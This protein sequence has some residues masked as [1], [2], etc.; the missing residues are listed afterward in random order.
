MKIVANKHFEEEKPHTRI[1]HELFKNAL[2]ASINIANALNYK[3]KKNLPF[4]YID[5]YAGAG[6]FEDG[7]EGSPLIAL[8]LISKYKEKKSF[9]SFEF[10]VTEND[11]INAE[12]LTTNIS[13]KKINLALTNDLCKHAIYCGRWEDITT[14]LSA[15]IKARKWGFVFVDPFSLELNLQELIN[16][17][18]NNIY[19]K[20]I[21]ILINKNAQERVLGKLDSQDIN[22]ICNYFG[23][24]EK[25]LIRLINYVKS[26]KKDCTN[27]DIIQLLTQNALKKVDKDFKIYAGISRT[28]QK[29]L[30][31]ADRFYLALLTSS[32]GVA[33]SFLYK[34]SEL[35]EEKE[36]KAKGGQQN[37]FD[38]SPHTK[39]MNLE[40]K[41][42][43]SL[44]SETITLYELTKRL[45]N[46]FLS[47]KYTED[48]QVPHR[49]A[50][51]VALNNLI[52]EKNIDVKITNKLP[53]RCF[54]ESKKT[55]L[56]EAFKTKDNLK[57]IYIKKLDR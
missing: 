35:L 42:I 57:Q 15:Y 8:N 55:I 34:Y 41:I 48:N 44:G 30:E 38:T 25:T 10:V 46:V 27:N 32:I 2:A 28:R 23:I 24:D 43:T 49:R 14:E 17:L 29:E 5:L 40:Q 53:K 36:Q 31:N 4:M 13:N 47:W 11:K 33:D 7:Q 54:N 50:I 9:S 39:Y 3:D 18:N 1:K 16:V 45:F 21:M 51:L 22:K 20:D 26:T 52:S 6:T 56:A 37:L 12:N 19:F